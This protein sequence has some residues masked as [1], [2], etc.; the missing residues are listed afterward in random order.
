MF[1]LDLGSDLNLDLDRPEEEDDEPPWFTGFLT[2]VSRDHVAHRVSRMDAGI[3]RLVQ[4]STEMD[5]GEN[6]LHLGGLDGRMLQLV[7]EYMEHHHGNVVPG[8]LWDEDF[9]DRF[10]R[11]EVFELVSVASYLDI[12]ELI[13]L[14][15]SKVASYV[16]HSKLE[17]SLV[18]H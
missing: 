18:Y 4:V 8:R 16:R 11:D 2:L 13:H 1:N 3:S 12:V 6:I 9:I 17:E 7:V 14:A 5:L 15:C 10:T